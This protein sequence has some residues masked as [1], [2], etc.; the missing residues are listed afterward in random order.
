MAARATKP[1]DSNVASTAAP[2]INRA[3]SAPMHQH[4][5]T[6]F[7]CPRKLGLTKGII[8]RVRES[9]FI[10]ARAY[11]PCTTV[12]ACTLGQFVERPA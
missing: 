5:P 9:T 8:P 12:A 1:N 3:R 4:R 7:P 2:P 11:L 10:L 6:H